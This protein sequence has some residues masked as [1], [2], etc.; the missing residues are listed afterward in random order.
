MNSFEN[1]NINYFG[2][3][4]KKEKEKKKTMKD[5]FIIK[6]TKDNK[7]TKGYKSKH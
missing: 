5:I 4:D 3:I 6:K 7:K 2:S 1:N